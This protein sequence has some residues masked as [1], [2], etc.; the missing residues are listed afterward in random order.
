MAVICRPGGP[1]RVCRVGCRNGTKS[2]AQRDRGVH[3]P[4]NVGERS[5]IPWAARIA[6]SRSGISQGVEP[7]TRQRQLLPHGERWF[8]FGG[9][10]RRR[11]GGKFLPLLRHGN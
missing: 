3:Q 9:D 10:Y 5:D 1:G 8:Y 6:T 2:V 11:F 7:A 4:T